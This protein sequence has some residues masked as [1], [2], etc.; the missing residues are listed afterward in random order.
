MVKMRPCPPLP[1]CRMTVSAW[2]SHLSVEA[3]RGGEVLRVE[4]PD[5]G[6]Y[7]MVERIEKFSNDWGKGPAYQKKIVHLCN[8]EDEIKAGDGPCKFDGGTP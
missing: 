8:N 4:N 1:N 3:A 2:S 6:D 7:V 5:T